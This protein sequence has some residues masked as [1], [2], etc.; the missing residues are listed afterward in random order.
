M[1]LRAAILTAAILL[2]LGAAA[3]FGAAPPPGPGTPGCDG[4]GMAFFAQLGQTVGEG[5]PHGV[6]GIAKFLDVTPAE[7]RDSSVANCAVPG[8][9]P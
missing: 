4:H 6:G 1:G 3:A 7:L 5:I 8:P 2:G 9:T